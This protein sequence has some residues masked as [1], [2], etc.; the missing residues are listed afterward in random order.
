MLDP[1]QPNFLSFLLCPSR[2]YNHVMIPGAAAG[3]DVLPPSSP[4][5]IATAE[6]RCRRVASREGQS[7]EAPATQLLSET[8]LMSSRCLDSGIAS[9]CIGSS[10][11]SRVDDRDGDLYCRITAAILLGYRS[12]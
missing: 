7:R 4:A 1:Y 8:V 10:E 9:S 6:Q 12:S 3:H 2:I 5:T 11:I